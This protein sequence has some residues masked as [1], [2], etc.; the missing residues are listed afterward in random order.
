MGDG[1]PAF[2][3]SRRRSSRMR[4]ENYSR[5]S[6]GG[7]P[8]RVLQ[9][10][11]CLPK[12]TTERYQT[13]L[14]R[15]ALKLSHHPRQGLGRVGR[16]ADHQV[17][18]ADIQRLARGEGAPLVVLGAA[19]G[20]TIKHVFLRPPPAAPNAIFIKARLSTFAGNP[21]WMGTSQPSKP[22]AL[23]SSNPGFKSEGKSGSA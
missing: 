19:G 20:V 1:G 12:G 10:R 18:R 15:S 3:R 9:T 22:E 21:L 7:R 13:I 4:L 8:R 5:A 23:Q 16:L 17:I 11:N 14:D 2:R 6:P